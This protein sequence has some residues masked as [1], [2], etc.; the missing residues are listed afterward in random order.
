MVIGMPARDKHCAGQLAM[1]PRPR[2]GLG[3][4]PSLAVRDARNHLRCRPGPVDSDLRRPDA[5]G[6]SGC[7]LARLGPGDGC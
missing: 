7:R 1:A 6:K 4:Y 5:P 2:S 3:A